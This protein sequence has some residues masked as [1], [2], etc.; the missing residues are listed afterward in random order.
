MTIEIVETT[1]DQIRKVRK[2]IN[3]DEFLFR[4]S[5]TNEEEIK[6]LFGLLYSRGL[7]HDIKQPTKETKELWMTRFLQEKYTGQQCYYTDTSG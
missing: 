5:D 3:E 2:K 4:Y 1:N 6:C 7:Y